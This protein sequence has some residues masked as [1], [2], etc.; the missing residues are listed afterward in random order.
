MQQL[1]YAYSNVD[2][3][4]DGG[5]INGVNHMWTSGTQYVVHDGDNDDS[6]NDVFTS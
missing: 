4:D 2:H 1:G 3:D 6:L 5:T